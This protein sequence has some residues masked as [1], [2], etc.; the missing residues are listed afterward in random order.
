MAKDAI[1]AKSDRDWEIE[2]A[3]DTLMR[4]EEIE[5]NSALHKAAVAK[6]KE[7]KAAISRALGARDKRQAALSKALG[8]K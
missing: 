6:L 3:A 4:A 5:A 2:Q 7:R 8:K 1:T